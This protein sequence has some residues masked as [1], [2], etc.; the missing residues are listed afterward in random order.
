[1]FGKIV[2]NTRTQNW[3][4]F[5]NSTLNGCFAV[6]VHFSQYI[7]SK[8]KVQFNIVDIQGGKTCKIIFSMDIEWFILL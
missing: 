8:K 7:T 5:P 3:L 2:H 6:G 1:M 4:H